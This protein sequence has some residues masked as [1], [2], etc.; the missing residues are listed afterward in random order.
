[1]KLRPSWIF[2]RRP[3]FPY[4]VSISFGALLFILGTGIIGLAAMDADVNLLV[5]IFGLC[6]AA[7]LIN[8]FYGW[9]GLRGLIVKRVLPD[10][11]I[12]GQPFII[13]YELR[14]RRRW[15]CARGILVQ[16]V[17]GRHELMASPEMFVP[18]LRPGETV[19][20]SVPAVCHSRGKIAFSSLRISTRF[21]FGIFSK[22]IVLHSEHDLVVF[23]PLGRLLTDVVSA[24]QSMDA[25][26]GM[27]NAGRHRGDE[28]YYGVR[29]Y[30]V[31]DNPRRIHWRRS[32]HTGQLM[33]RE[34]S[35][36]QNRQIWCVVSTQMS[37]SS[38]AD[39][40]RIESVL[41]AAATVICD[42]L[43]RGVQ[44][45]LICDGDPFVIFPPGGGRAHR[46][47]LLR[48]LAL[49]NIVPQGELAD[50]I[51]HLAWPTRW[52]G[53]CILFAAREDKDLDGAV[54]SISKAIGP[55]SLFVAGTVEFEDVFDLRVIVDPKIIL[56]PARQS[57]SLRRHRPPKRA[58]R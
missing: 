55:V 21:P 11:A 24:S 8:L 14:Y 43:E 12:C 20:L 39:K 58:R 49:R 26:G 46:P 53:P 36:A 34:M 6:V 32:A 40:S 19:T 23:P 27:G 29:E 31:G 33:I 22:Y 1:M 16:D 45:G 54:D 44:V 17:L 52:H 25:A 51:R 13:R 10:I 56:S 5:L 7:L 37:S 28:E 18:V 47:R 9:R 35:K 57:S 41:S 3:G 4:R 48:E 15:S 2:S 50:H 42:A 38:E 30:R